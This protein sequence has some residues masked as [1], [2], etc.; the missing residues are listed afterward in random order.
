MVPP[1]RCAA[2]HFGGGMV[3]D[4]PDKSQRVF[5]A[6]WPDASVHAVLAELAREVAHEGGG[7]ATAASLIHLT[8]A[9]LG[10]QPA[11][12]VESL[13]SLGGG[14]RA[15]AFALALDA[16]GGFA[17]TGIAWL[18]ASAP[19]PELAEL[20]GELTT[21]LRVRGFAVDERPYAPHLTLARRSA[22]TIERR[23]PQPI[24]WRVTSFMLVVSELG[25]KGPA[26]R[27]LA[28]WPL[29]GA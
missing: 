2:S 10:D 1:G 7:R 9:F 20:H 14:I 18:G 24:C 8:L 13:R 16:I 23:L 4:A 19:Q 6:L 22:A 27:R 29:D 25:R 21:A 12:Q 3:P 5:F 15:R 28:E 11:I 17:R 26:Y